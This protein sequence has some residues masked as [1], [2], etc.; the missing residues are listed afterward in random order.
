MNVESL[1]D[2]MLEEATR[3]LTANFKRLIG[4]TCHE[5]NG[6]IIAR[7]TCKGSCVSKIFLCSSEGLEIFKNFLNVQIEHYRLHQNFKS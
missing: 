5:L 2:E 1:V 7:I 4:F 3:D 6:E